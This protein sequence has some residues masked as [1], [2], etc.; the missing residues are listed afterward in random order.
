MET[1]NLL[2]SQIDEDIF[3]PLQL[4]LLELAK[5]VCTD[6]VINTT[7]FNISGVDCV[8]PG[9]YLLKLLVRQYGFMCLKE[10][11]VRHPWVIPEGLHTTEVSFTEITSSQTTKH[12]YNIIVANEWMNFIPLSLA[13]DKNIDPFVIYKGAI[14]YPSLRDTVS[15]AVYGKQIEKLEE[16]TK[17]YIA[18]LLL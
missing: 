10:V 16:A 12:H 3:D 8:G 2:H 13:Q 6:P 4:D 5:E 7:D 11:S 9:I 18:M 1:A 17:V 14:D 15:E